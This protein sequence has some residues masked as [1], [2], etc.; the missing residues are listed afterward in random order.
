MRTALLAGLAGLLLCT[1]CAAPAKTISANGYRNAVSLG[2]RAEL[3]R[4]GISLRDRPECRSPDA[5]RART[6]SG[7]A[8]T[9]RA[10]ALDGAEVTM[11]GTV[12]GAGTAAQREDYVVRLDGRIVLHQD[13]LGAGCRRV[14]ALP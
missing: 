14:P 4:S 3:D 12:T 5:E 2:L 8:V 6:G 7:F 13:C 1:G 9:C 11:R 10:V